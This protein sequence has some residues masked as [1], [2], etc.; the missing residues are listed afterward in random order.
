MS[1][2]KDFCKVAKEVELAAARLASDLETV[3]VWKERVAEA[4]KELSYKKERARTA[5]LAYER[6][7]KRMQILL[8]RSEGGEK[9]KL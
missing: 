2:P 6:A 7:R 3:N 5:G 1:V 8:E 4:E 9:L